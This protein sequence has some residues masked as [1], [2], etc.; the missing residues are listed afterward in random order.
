MQD[1]FSWAADAS[2]AVET[3]SRAATDVESGRA[4]RSAEA[5][6]AKMAKRQRS[7][8]RCEMCA[9]YHY[10]EVDPQEWARCTLCGIHH[11]GY[12][13]PF[14]GATPADWR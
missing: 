13:T 4:R 11:G 7:T 10:R 1:L 6:A 12:C 9:S 14:H 5:R 3:P 2:Q 8:V